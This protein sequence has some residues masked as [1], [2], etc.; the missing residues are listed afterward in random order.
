M[1][2]LKNIKTRWILIAIFICALLIRLLMNIQFQGLNSPPD[3]DMGPDAIYY[4][5]LAQNL[6]DGLGYSING[7]PNTHYPPGIPFLLF[8]VYKIFGANYA[9]ARI[10]FSILGAATCVI[11]YSI[12]KN[13]VS[14]EIGI[15]SATL[16]ALYPM[17]FYYSMHFLPEVPIGFFIC[18]AIL[19]LLSFQE[20]QKVH[21]GILSGVFIGFSILITPRLIL[22]FPIYVCMTVIHFL[23]TREIKKLVS[24]TFIL[25]ISIGFSLFPWLIRNYIITD[26]FVPVATHGGVAFLAANNEII[27]NDP[28]KIGL[29][30]QDLKSIPGFEQIASLPAHQRSQAVLKLGLDFFKGQPIGNILKLEVMKLYRAFTPIY[31]TPNKVF[32][33]VGG[34]GWG[35]VAPFFFLGF[36]LS[37][38]NQRFISLHTIVFLFLVITL[39]FFGN[40]R[41]RASFSPIL[42]IYAGMGIQFL[43]RKVFKKE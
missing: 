42:M 34:I 38:K 41:Y 31:N 1:K 26:R 32:N 18:L 22:Y 10:F 7:K 24:I 12:G 9:L 25:G 36:L 28:D 13:L 15:I 27:M 3:P 11:L 35:L 33:A 30:V 23:K 2:H 16:L 8:F 39:I 37:V 6:A 43:Y 14:K 21:M 40:Y 4:D 5:Q 17:H 29:A 20:E 19:C